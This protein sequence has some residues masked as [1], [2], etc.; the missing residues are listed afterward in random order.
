[1]TNFKSF[2]ILNL[3]LK[4][5]ISLEERLTGYKIQVALDESII[6]YAIK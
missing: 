6:K 1:M 5:K 3:S 4:Q 2:K